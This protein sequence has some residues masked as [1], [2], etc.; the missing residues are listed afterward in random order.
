[1]FFLDIDAQ[2]EATHFKNRVLDLVDIYVKKQP[3][4]PYLMRLILPLVDLIADASLDER[5]LSDKVT[6]LLRNRLGK[7]KDFPHYIDAGEGTTVLHELHRRARKASSSELLATLSQCCLYVS[8]T[9]LNSE[10]DNSVLQAYRGSLVD[11]ITRKASTINAT[12][13][14]DFIRRFPTL[15]WSL[16]DDIMDA[17]RKAANI[18]RQCQAFQLFHVIINQTPALV[19]TIQYTI[20]QRD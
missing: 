13:L 8:K 5:Q 10:G 1:M 2:R 20:N 17:S 7:A 11:F 18:Y 12:F 3:A 15:G 19:R 6:G 4:N 9:M 14:L 16:R